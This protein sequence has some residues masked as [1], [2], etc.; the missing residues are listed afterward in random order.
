MDLFDT[1]LIIGVFNQLSVQTC[2]EESLPTNH[3][4]SFIGS[5]YEV[6]HAKLKR[7]YSNFGEFSAN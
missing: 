7:K 4:D 3:L 2:N 1:L 5:N 6:I